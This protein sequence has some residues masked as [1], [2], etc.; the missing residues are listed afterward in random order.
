MVAVKYWIYKLIARFHAED[1]ASALAAAAKAQSI[2]ELKVAGFEYADYHFYAALAH[3]AS[4]NSSSVDDRTRHFRAL[5]FHYEQLALWVG[6]YRAIF[7]SK[8]ALVGAEVA[9]LEGRLLDAESLYEEALRSARLN[10]FIYKEGLTYELAA[11]FYGGRGFDTFSNEYLQSA[12]SC[13]LRW[14]AERKVRYMD[15]KYPH[16]VPLQEQ[17]GGPSST[18]G[19]PVGQLDLATVLRVS[20]AVSGEIDF[21]SLIKTLMATAL[22]HAGAQRGLLILTRGE[23][24]WIEAEASTAHDTISVNRRN[25][26][27]APLAL[28]DAVYRY[29]IRTKESVLLHDASKQDPFATDEYI[30]R[31]NSRSILCLPL[32]KQN[33]L[34]GML[35]VENGLAP[36]VFTPAR[37]TVLSL[38]ASQAAILLENASL[39]SHLRDADTYLKEAQRLSHIGSFRWGGAAGPIVWSE[40]MYRIY[41]FDRSS[42]V[43][44]EKI[45]QRIHRDDVDRVRDLMQRK[46]AH[47]E[48]FELEH[49]IV[50]LDGSIK[51]LRIVVHAVTGETGGWSSIGAVMDITSSKEAQERLREAQAELTHAGRLTT[52]GAL[53]ASIA[54]EISQPL[55]AVVTNAESCWQW[56]SKEPPDLYKAREAAERIVKNGHRAG[57]VIKS[58]RAMARKSESALVTLNINTVI[59]DTLDLMHSELRRHEVSLETQLAKQLALIKADRTQLQQVIVNLVMNAIEA[60]GASRG[61]RRSLRTVTASDE[62]GHVLTSIEDTGPGIDAKILD[63]IFI[64]MFTTKPEGMGLGLSICRSIIETLGGQLWVSP[65]PRGGS[66]FQFSIPQATN[67]TAGDAA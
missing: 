2:P 43:T 14:G 67:E 16:L 31:N 57:D 49:R 47:N 38:L 63:Q 12:R 56:L 23:E 51:H 48:D 24:M 26:R 35:Y 5:V 11:R 9:R 66:I 61:S 62:H 53:A 40:E 22:E 60:M 46:A 42:E 64:P 37:I 50:M 30:R 15:L 6:N 3:A 52:L 33:Q 28:P 58:I 44:F 8:K 29:V 34:M 54:H 59:R 32:V 39:Y 4:C 55:M 17:R 1:Y 45:F 27:V 65:N 21:N 36:G 18:L 10:G 20:Q 13:Y 41:E 25:M 7:A 19:T